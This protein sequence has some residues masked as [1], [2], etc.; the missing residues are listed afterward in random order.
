MRKILSRWDRPTSL[1]NTIADDLFPLGW[2]VKDRSE[3]LELLKYSIM[4][5]LLVKLQFDLELKTRSWYWTTP[6]LRSFTGRLDPPVV[7]YQA[8]LRVWTELGG[9]LSL[10]RSA[11]F[12]SR[13]SCPLVRYFFAV[14]R[15]VMGSRTPSL[16]SLH[17]IVDRQRNFMDW[18]IV[19]RRAHATKEWDDYVTICER[20]WPHLAPLAR[21][22]ADAMRW[23]YLTPQEQ[24]RHVKRR[25]K[26]DTN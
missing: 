22:T 4:D 7:Y 16:L 2:S 18:L 26:F 1:A 24:A 9:R 21:R 11:G 6:I 5:A 10:S 3:E 8:I 23:R 13:V 25:R 19:W 14:V 12:S 20:R 17:D 15:P